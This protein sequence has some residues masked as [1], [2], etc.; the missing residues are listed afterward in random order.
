[1]GFREDLVHPDPPDPPAS[2]DPPAKI[3][4]LL[5]MT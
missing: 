5:R 4:G 3:G 1:M 2:P